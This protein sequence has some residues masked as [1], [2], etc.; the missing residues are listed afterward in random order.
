MSAMRLVVMAWFIVIL[1]GAIW[2]LS[3]CDKQPTTNVYST[4]QVPPQQRCEAYT[5]TGVGNCVYNPNCPPPGRLC[6][7]IVNMNVL[8]YSCNPV[9]YSSQQVCR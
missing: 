8:T 2:V 7:T 5:V 1:I 9:L 6:E 4:N 3:G